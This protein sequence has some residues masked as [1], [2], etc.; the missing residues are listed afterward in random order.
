MMVRFRETAYFEDCTVGACFE[1]R[2]GG[3]STLD[4]ALLSF[5][6][7]DALRFCSRASWI[8]ARMSSNGEAVVPSLSLR[9]LRRRLVWGA[10]EAWALARAPNEMLFREDFTSP[11]SSSS[12]E[13]G[14]LASESWGSESN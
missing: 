6:A 8:L 3:L 14:S 13:M 12:S 4:F 9:F 2:D 5:D 10:K 7:K 1:V 11:S